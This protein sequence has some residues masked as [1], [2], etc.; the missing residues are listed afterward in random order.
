M[1]A[2]THWGC[3]LWFFYNIWLLHCFRLLLTFIPVKK[4]LVK[5]HILLQAVPLIPFQTWKGPWCRALGTML[6]IRMDSLLLYSESSRRNWKWQWGSE[7]I[8][9]LRVNHSLTDR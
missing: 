7:A 5:G 8:W 1:L 3:N 6:N 9:G 4:G 2:P